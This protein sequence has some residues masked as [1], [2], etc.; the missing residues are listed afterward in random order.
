MWKSVF[1]QNVR[2]ISRPQFHLSLLGS[3]AFLRT[4]RHLATKVGTPKIVEGNGK[5][6]QVL[7]QDAVFQSHTGHMTG[8][9]FLP[10]RTLRLN[11]NEG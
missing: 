1:R 10:T 3:L 2:T 9:C 4:Y 7:A 8:L 5:L 11:T 6:P